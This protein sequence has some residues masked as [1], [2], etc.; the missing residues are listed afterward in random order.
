MY[1][2]NNHL[3]SWVLLYWPLLF[4]HAHEQHVAADSFCMLLW[5]VLIQ[6]E[7]AAQVQATATQLFWAGI[8]QQKRPLGHNGDGGRAAAEV[9][10]TRNIGRCISEISF[11]KPL[12]S[13]PFR[14]F[15]YIYIYIM[16]HCPR[17]SGGLIS[18]PGCLA[19]CVIS[20]NRH[21]K[22]LQ[23]HQRLYKVVIV[24]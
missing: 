10:A 11:G 4:G 23:W 12:D 2:L 5:L 18:F 17:L 19:P 3:R 21:H 1:M 24:I 22:H 15:L 7:R 8:V 16:P 13:F 14:Y 9:A 6:A 20:L